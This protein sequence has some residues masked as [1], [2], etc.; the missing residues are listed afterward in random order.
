MKVKIVGKINKDGT[1]TCDTVK[2]AGPDCKKI[3]DIFMGAIGKIDESSRA[4]TPD[5][6]I[7]LETSQDLHIGQ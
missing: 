2:G 7:P 1:V 3:A 4:D 6:D 5:L